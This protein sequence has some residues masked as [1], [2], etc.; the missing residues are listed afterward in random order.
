MVQKPPIDITA[1]LQQGAWGLEDYYAEPRRAPFARGLNLY[2]LV[3]VFF[4]GSF[5]GVAFETILRLLA[6]GAFVR[7]AGML[8]GPFNQVYGLGA[9]LFLLCLYPLRRTH[10]LVIFAVATLLGLV[11]EYVCSW[12]QEGVFR[13]TSWDYSDIPFNL[14]GRTNLLYGLGWGLLGYFFIRHLW[15]WISRNVE[16]LPPKGGR[17]VTIVLAVL[18]CI[19]LGLSALAVD[20]WQQ[21][22]AGDRVTNSVAS[23][24][25]DKNYP[26]SVM[27]EKYP[28]LRFKD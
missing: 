13:S 22:D 19:D 27:E 10:G 17:V 6:T 16:R 23:R 7:T 26:D 15:P 25:L 4:L 11:F 18:L 12:V 5:I 20:R 21:R 2:K 28:S 3:W 8:Y 24:W 14:G 1:M 9:V